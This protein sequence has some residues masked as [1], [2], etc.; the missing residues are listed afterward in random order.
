M[1]TLDEEPLSKNKIEI[2]GG[3]IPVAIKNLL[4]TFKNTE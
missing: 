1:D 2:L 3:H 4:T